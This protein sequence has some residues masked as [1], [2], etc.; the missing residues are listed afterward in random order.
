MDVE[1]I[2]LEQEV[3]YPFLRKVLMDVAELRRRLVDCQRA[4]EESCK[5][6]GEAR[7]DAEENYRLYR[8]AEEQIEA[9]EKEISKKGRN[10]RRLAD[11]GEYPDG[12]PEKAKGKKR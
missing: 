12:K 9:L 1:Q 5:A 4:Y 10:K 6:A 8:E 11:M 7:D 2:K 3:F